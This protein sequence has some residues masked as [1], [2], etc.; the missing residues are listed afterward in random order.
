ME[1]RP[2][3]PNHQQDARDRP[4]LVDQVRR[5]TDLAFALITD[6]EI[7]AIRVMEH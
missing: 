1:E 7:G 4:F 2:L 3:A 5:R 6:T